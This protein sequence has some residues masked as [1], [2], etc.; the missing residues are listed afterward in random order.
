VSSSW[1][2]LTDDETYG[3]PQSNGVAPRRPQK[4][5]NPAAL[6][7]SGMAVAEAAARTVRRI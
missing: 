6:P 3:S 1:G 7:P 4:V 5:P 2:E